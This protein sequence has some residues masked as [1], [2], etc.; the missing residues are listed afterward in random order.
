MPILITE[1][2][3]VITDEIEAQVAEVTKFIVLR[4]WQ[5]L[6]LPPQEGGTPR[7]TGHASA[8]WIISIGSPSDQV[9]GSNESKDSVDY[10]PAR[11]G[12]DSLRGYRLSQGA[13]F[14]VNNTAYI[15]ALNYGL[16]RQAQAGFVERAQVR[17]VNDAEQKFRDL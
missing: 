9:G 6:T 14:L 1:Y 11:E 3:K 17:A 16:S 2:P 10:G 5:N 7:R 15:V 12:V 13:L 8:S 4:T